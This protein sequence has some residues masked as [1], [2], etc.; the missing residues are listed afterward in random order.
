MNSFC[1]VGDDRDFSCV[2]EFRETLEAKPLDRHKL[3]VG[4]G[5]EGRGLSNH[6][7]G[8]LDHHHSPRSHLIGVT[9]HS[10]IQCLCMLLIISY[11]YYCF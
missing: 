9:I 6:Q 3:L 4:A 2:V 11:C 10:L 7:S 5:G 1:D 8:H